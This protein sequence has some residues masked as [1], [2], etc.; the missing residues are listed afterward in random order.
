MAF[1]NCS[2]LAKVSNPYGTVGDSQLHVC[3]SRIL[4][5]VE[6]GKKAQQADRE[7]GKNI[8]QQVEMYEAAKKAIGE[9]RRKVC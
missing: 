9:Q 6:E 7:E 3:F 5:H 2:C 1:S 8:K 4:D